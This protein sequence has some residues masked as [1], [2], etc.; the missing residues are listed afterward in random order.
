MQCNNSFKQNKIIIFNELN[1]LLVI[2]MFKDGCLIGGK[3][4]L[5]FLWFD[6]SQQVGRDVLQVFC[7][8]RIGTRCLR[9]LIRSYSFSITLA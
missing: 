7:Q 1:T 3:G 8:R 5:D 4:V 6:C 2:E 9:A